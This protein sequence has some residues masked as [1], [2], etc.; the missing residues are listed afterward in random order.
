MFN[1]LLFIQFIHI[2]HSAANQFSPNATRAFIPIKFPI[3]FWCFNERAPL[4]EMKK[5]Y[6]G[7]AK[8]MWWDGKGREKEV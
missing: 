3:V 6:A 5:L 4:L 7:M 2:I 1:E 8:S